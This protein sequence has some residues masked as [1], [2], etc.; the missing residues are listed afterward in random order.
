MGEIILEVNIFFFFFLDDIAQ[1]DVI[2]YQSQ[3][4]NVS[5]NVLFKDET[6][7]MPQKDIALLFGVDRSVI[8]KHFKNIFNEEE[9]SEGSVCAKFAHTATDGKTYNTLFYNLDAIIAVGY[10]VNSKEATQFRIWATNV[11]QEYIRKGFALNDDMLKNGRSFGQDYFKELLLRIRS[12]RTSERRIYQQITDIFEQCAIDYDSNSPTTKDFFATVQNKFHFAITGQTAAEIIYASADK[13][14]PNMGLQT[15]SKSP[16]GRIYQYDVTVAKNYLSEDDI[17][18]LERTVN[19]FFDYI[20]G[21]VERRQT[22]TMKAFAES[23]DKFLSFNEYRILNTKGS[24]AKKVA[25]EKAINEYKEFNKSQ[26]V[27]SEFD[28]LVQKEK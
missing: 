3:N 14:V 27:L 12:I 8:T 10:R 23:V 13:N 20:E 22:F 28:K 9:L 6:F 1:N 24:I 15:W 7:W 4:E 26:K 21:I 5:T 25:D 17:K 18:K 19:A 2:I 16:D 11:L